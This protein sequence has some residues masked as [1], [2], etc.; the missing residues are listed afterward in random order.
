M[1]SNEELM[2]RTFK[3]STKE[4]FEE[5]ADE[6]ADVV[7]SSGSPVSYKEAYEYFMKTRYYDNLP[8]RA[9]QG[10]LKND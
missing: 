8:S 1:M 5:E 6:Y 4:K 9:S 3:K 10:M 7:A 2:F